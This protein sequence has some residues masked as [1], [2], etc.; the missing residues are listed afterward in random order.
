M[1]TSTCEWMC[2]AI[3]MFEL[4]ELFYFL[5]RRSHSLV[6]FLLPRHN[7]I[8]VLQLFTGAYSSQILS[9]R[10]KNVEKL[11][12]VIES[13][14][15]MQVHNRIKPHGLSSNPFEITLSAPC[16]YYLQHTSFA[17]FVPNL[18][19][20]QVEYRLS[21]SSHGSYLNNYIMGQLL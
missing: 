17:R 11:Q 16:S 10:A 13:F 19:T 4:T 14:L 7:I 2:F 5:F 9:E 18:W 6:T 3:N 15:N 8:F 20:W 12:L 1:Y 21:I